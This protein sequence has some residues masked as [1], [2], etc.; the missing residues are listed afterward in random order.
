MFGVISFLCIIILS[1]ISLNFK[2]RSKWIER[3]RRPRFVIIVR[4][5]ASC[6]RSSG[7]IAA[8]S[9]RAA[10][11]A[12]PRSHLARGRVATASPGAKI[13]SAKVLQSLKKYLT[14]HPEAGPAILMSVQNGDFEIKKKESSDIIP[15]D[16]NNIME[17]MVP[18]TEAMWQKVKNAAGKAR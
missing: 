9:V 18:L 3:S 15:E 2:L 13:S 5:C 6:V 12:I 11:F 14:Q 10:C 4:M 7:A 8:Q 1:R 17:G 16:K